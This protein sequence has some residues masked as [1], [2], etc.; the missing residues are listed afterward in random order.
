MNTQ[1]VMM[2]FFHVDG[3]PVEVEV[4]LKPGRD[5]KEVYS[6]LVAEVRKAKPKAVKIRRVSSRIE[7]RD[8]STIGPLKLTDGMTVR[9]LFPLGGDEK[10]LFLK[11]G[12]VFFHGASCDI[13][14]RFSRG[15][16][17]VMITL[18]DKLRH[19]PV[20]LTGGFINGGCAASGLPALITNLLG[21]TARE[22]TL[23]F[24]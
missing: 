6:D 11:V 16:D 7:K 24:K 15:Q 3:E 18:H 13:I 4:P 14:L 5:P 21:P 22:L 10:S 17:R 1:N 12:Q 23:R 9:Q 19:T 20:N 8:P 2:G